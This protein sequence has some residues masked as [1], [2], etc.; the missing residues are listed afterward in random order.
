MNI[1]YD[2]DKPKNPPFPC[3]MKSKTGLTIIMISSGT[4]FAIPGKIHKNGLY[5]KF[6]DISKFKP[7]TGTVTLSNM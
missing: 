7:M 1:V 6:W 2:E 4:G 5:S 3:I